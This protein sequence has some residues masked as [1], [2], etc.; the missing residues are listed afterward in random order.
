M[1]QESEPISILTIR[2]ADRL[3]LTVIKLVK[4]GVLDARSEAGD[5]VL[6]YASMRFGDSNPIGDMEKQAQ[7]YENNHPS[8]HR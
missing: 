1:Q 6:N 3:A 7:E 2:A 4:S 8:Q 5:Q